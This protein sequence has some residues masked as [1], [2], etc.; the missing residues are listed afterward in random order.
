MSGFVFISHPEAQN[1]P[2]IPLERASNL[3][4]HRGRQEYIHANENFS[5][6]YRVN[7]ADDSS[8]TKENILFDGE[9]HNRTQLCNERGVAPDASEGELLDDLY[10]SSGGKP[11]EALR[12]GIFSM[13]IHTE[14]GFYCARDPLGIKTLFYQEANG[15]RFFA[16][17]LKALEPFPGTPREFPAGHWMDGAGRLHRYADIH[18]EV[19]EIPTREKSSAHRMAEQVRKIIKERLEEQV[20]FELPTASLLSGGIDSSAIASLAA[21]RHREKTGKPLSTY[22]V[23]IGESEDIRKARVVAEHIG[24]EHSEI[25]ISLEK[26]ESLLPRVIYYLESFDPSLVRSSL[27]N[28]VVAEAAASDGN[29]L[30]LSGEGGDELFAGYA[31]LL[32]ADASQIQKGQLEAL[33]MLHN[34]ASLRLDRMNQANGLRVV[35]PMISGELLRYAFS[36]PSEYRIYRDESGRAME[37]WILREAFRHDLPESI[38]NRRKQEFSQGSG[39]ADALKPFFEK[40][41]SDT[42]LNHARSDYPF[43]RSKEEYS[44]FRIFLDNF[45]ASAAET[46]GQWDYTN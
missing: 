19:A 42:E 38:L 5:S 17:E 26:L 41:V 3:I 14:D 37:K 15:S 6:V 32:D 12:D 39:S 33:S 1:R 36:I 29:E 30:V 35:A 25:L 46:V 11:H 43:I 34:N 4:S 10:N 31:N 45:S 7:Q 24:S 9:I 44:Y 8:E 28:Y 40:M 16:S 22:A 20:D 21:P 18:R 13:A 27:V 2:Q 23:G